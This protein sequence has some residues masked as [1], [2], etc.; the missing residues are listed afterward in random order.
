MTSV[1]IADQVGEMARR[2][3]QE[4]ADPRMEAFA[5]EQADLRAAGQPDGVAEA[6]ATLPDAQLLDPDGAPRS[7]SAA[8]G[9]PLTV[10]VLY[11]GAWCPY[12]NI[13]LRTYQQALLPRLA[14]RE[15]P[16][17]AISPQKPDGS[18]TMRDKH[19]LEFE[20]LS[21]PGNAIARALGVLTEPV[22]DSREAQLE[23]GLDLAQVNADGTT[24]IPMPT[25]VVV[26]RDLAIQWIDVHPDYS[27]RSEPAEICAALDRLEAPSSS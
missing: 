24:G 9:A 20:V 19:D 1:T 10:L 22:A 14:E 7:L 16:L 23:L 13:A 2:A 17:I 18:L 4:P 3:A 6:G 12:C 5:R 25:T 21:D 26:D 27:T 15:V 11:R 8:V